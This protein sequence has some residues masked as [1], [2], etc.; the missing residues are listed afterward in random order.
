MIFTYLLMLAEGIFLI[1]KSVKGL[2]NFTPLIF[3][4]YFSSYCFLI[5][6]L[7]VGVVMAVVSITSLIQMRRK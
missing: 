5:F 1:C 3:G 6:A 2:L 7:A 4:S